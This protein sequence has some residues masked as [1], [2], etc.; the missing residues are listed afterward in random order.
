MDFKEWLYDKAIELA[1]KKFNDAMW[2]QENITQEVSDYLERLSLR[3]ANEELENNPN[4]GAMYADDCQSSHDD[5][6]YDRQKEREMG[7]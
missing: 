7:L 2:I 3:H 4:I 6:L 5:D 1:D